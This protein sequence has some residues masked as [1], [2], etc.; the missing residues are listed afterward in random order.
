MRQRA[1]SAAFLQT[2]TLNL[3]V[4]SGAS[5]A[6]LTT[7]AIDRLRLAVRSLQFAPQ[8]YCTSSQLDEAVDL[9]TLV[10]LPLLVP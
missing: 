1:E 9:P 5:A 6:C 2:Y 4:K 3:L 7:V 8:G 10:C